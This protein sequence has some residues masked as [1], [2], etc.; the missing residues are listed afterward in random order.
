[1]RI[2]LLL[3]LACPALAAPDYVPIAAARQRAS[4]ES[5]TVLGLV[6]VP[7]G[8]FR[9][10]ADEG[11]AVQDQTGGIWVTTKENR[12]LRQGQLVLVRGTLG[13]SAK[14]LVIQATAVAVQH[15]VLRVATKQVGPSTSGF[16][17]TVE[18]SIR[19][20]TADPPYGNKV[21]IDDGSGPLQVFVNAST[22]IDVSKLKIGRTIRVTGFSSN[23]EEVY[24]IEPR[25]RADVQVR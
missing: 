14:K 25:S 9:A 23:Y 17:I 6:T 21:F 5:V 20:I 19:S 1:M 13:T 7:S 15:G 24:E 22:D 8:R 11:F 4:G 12:G 2:V 3:L 10:A 18:G 16:L